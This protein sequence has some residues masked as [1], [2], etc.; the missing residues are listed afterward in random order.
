[1][2]KQI[3]ND[4]SS[5]QFFIND[6]VMSFILISCPTVSATL[7]FSN[8]NLIRN[9]LQFLYTCCRCVFLC[10]N[11]FN[12]IL[13]STFLFRSRC[14]NGTDICCLKPFTIIIVLYGTSNSVLFVIQYAIS[15]LL[16]TQDYL[17]IKDI[18]DMGIQLTALYLR[19]KSNQ[20]SVNVRTDIQR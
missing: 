15:T 13:G 9:A 14:I 10:I 17:T 1:M 8:F 3:V 12:L 6:W 5:E 18:H 16:E 2:Q 4:C 11:F 20:I 7:K 19:T